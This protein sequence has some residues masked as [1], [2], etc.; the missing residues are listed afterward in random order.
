MLCKQ[1]IKSFHAV[2]AAVP[3]VG[4]L[5]GCATPQ[6]TATTTAVEPRITVL[7]D[8]FGKPSSMTKDWG[9]SAFIEYG[10]KRILFDT[11]D[12][13][14]ILAQNA[15]AKGIDLSKLDFVVMSHRHGD[16]MGGMTY[17]LSVNPKVK[18]YAP[19]ENF[20]V[21]GFDLPSKFYRKAESLPPEQR[22][23]DGAPPEIMRFGS[24]WPG[25]NFQLIDKTTEIAPGVYL[26]ALVSDK[27][28]TLELKELS[29]AIETPDGI[30]LVVGCAHP[31][32]DRVVD[33]ASKINSRIH[34]IAGGFHLV[35]A[36]DDAIGKIVNQLH[37][38]YQVEYIAP[39]HC[40]GEPTFVQLKQAFGDHYLYAGLGTTIEVGANP[41]I[42]AMSGEDPNPTFDAQDLSTYRALLATSDDLEPDRVAISSSR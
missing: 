27:P 3:L 29:L 37:D 19:K 21:Y 11:G 7:Y 8:A 16:H 6:T 31:G 20:G 2:F 1:I 5:A 24:A 10:G 4:L 41:H 36:Q 23:Y 33:A 22:Y 40:T 9:Y 42:I 30:V 26:I 32:I 28:T 14:D 18:I 38:T 13:P 39:G 15:K 25:A 17:L 35:V 12:N 34:F